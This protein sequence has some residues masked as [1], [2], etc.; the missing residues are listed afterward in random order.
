M[1]CCKVPFIKRA[2]MIVATVFVVLC[3]VGASSSSGQECTWQVS[4][5][6]TDL[7]GV[8][9]GRDL[10]SEAAA[11]IP[12]YR[13]RIEV[14][15]WGAPRPALCL[16]GGFDASRGACVKDANGDAAAHER[17]NNACGVWDGPARGYLIHNTSGDWG[18]AWNAPYGGLDA[19]SCTEP[20]VIDQDTGECPTSPIL[21]PLT[22]MQAVRLTS[23]KDGVYFDLDADGIPERTAWTMS[24]SRLA[25]LALDRNGNGVID[26][27]SELFGDRTLP[28]VGDGFTALRLTNEA[29]GAPKKGSVSEGDAL[30]DALLLWEDVNHNGRSE[31]HE[32]QPAK[33]TVT[34]IGVGH[35]PFK[36]RD[37]HGNE[38]R[39]RGWAEVRTK[40]PGQ[41]KAT[42]PAD[43]QS[44]QRVIYDVFF[45]R[46]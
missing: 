18:S 30:Y 35:T 21:I 11:C 12:D 20:C 46:Q 43:H 7:P 44:R 24:D 34:R 22:N 32:L 45:V 19:G 27:G 36:R 37:G 8:V 13:S 5:W 31:P 39:F 9:N 2:A 14:W 15:I 42:D 38:L 41:K 28:D 29:M 1:N 25:F 33:N 17:L 23:A 10:T 26:D 16:Q 40:G 6:G 4:G 3:S